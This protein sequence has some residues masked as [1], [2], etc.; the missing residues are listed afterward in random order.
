MI[1]S[2]HFET[3]PF[4]LCQNPSSRMISARFLPYTSAPRQLGCRLSCAGLYHAAAGIVNIYGQYNSRRRRSG[5]C[6]AR[7][8]YSK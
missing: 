6:R 2:D 8:G 7:A 4:A 3:T 5:A 1:L